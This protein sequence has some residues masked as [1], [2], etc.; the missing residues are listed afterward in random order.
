MIN[1]EDGMNET[2]T[3][4]KLAEIMGIPDTY[5]TVPNIC[6][7]PFSR[8]GIPGFAHCAEDRCQGYITQ[9]CL[10]K[11]EMADMLPQDCPGTET[12][13]KCRYCK[14]FDFELPIIIERVR[15]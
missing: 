4:N 2:E 8:F 10:T 6:P 7:G 1:A 11:A 12:L 3:I 13:V 9:R 15:V 14:P 5:K